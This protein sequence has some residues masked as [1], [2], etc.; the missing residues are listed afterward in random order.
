MALILWLDW[1]KALLFVFLPWVAAMAMLTGVNLLQ[2]DG[3]R[4]DEP[5]HTSRNFIGRLGNWFFLNNGFHTAHHLRPNLH[6]S[7]LPGFHREASGRI[8]PSL[9]RRSILA[10][11]FTHYLFAIRTPAQ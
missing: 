4:P 6:W 2:H 1:Q 10:Y 5:M 11:L 7:R 9:K 3:C 8:P